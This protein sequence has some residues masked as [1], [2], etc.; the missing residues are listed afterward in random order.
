[1]S[2]AVPRWCGKFEF[3][4]Y[5]AR[6][7]CREEVRIRPSSLLPFVLFLFLVDFL[8]SASLTTMV[9]SVSTAATTSFFVLALHAALGHGANLPT[10]QSRRASHNG[11]SMKGIGTGVRTMNL[12]GASSSSSSNVSVNDFQDI[13]VSSIFPT[14]RTGV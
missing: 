13:L 3:K 11:M 7:G 14:S 10:T 9:P 4:I 8:V 2:G 6:R 12:A 5:E 1:M